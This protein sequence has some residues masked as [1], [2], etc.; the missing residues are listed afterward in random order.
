MASKR[1]SATP[2]SERSGTAAVERL[3]AICLVLPETTEKVAWGEPTWRVGGRLFAQLDDHH[4]G[5]D[6]LAV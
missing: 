6:H 5:A 1:K 3:R 4:H 2:R